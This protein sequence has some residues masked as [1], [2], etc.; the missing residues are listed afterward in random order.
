MAPGVLVEA[1]PKL[2]L[3][4]KKGHQ[5]AQGSSV[6]EDTSAFLRQPQRFAHL[7]QEHVFQGG[8]G[9]PHLV[10]R[11][12]VVEQ[13]GQGTQHGFLRE[14][15]GHLVAHVPRVVQL[16]GA[17]QNGTNGLITGPRTC[18]ERLPIRELFFGCAHRVAGGAAATHAV[19]EVVCQPVDQ[20]V[21]K[22]AKGHWVEGF[23]QGGMQGE[24][25]AT[26]GHGGAFHEGT[27]RPFGNQSASTI[28][29]LGD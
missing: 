29:S 25:G 5:V 15:D 2:A 24:Q 19:V 16:V 26:G 10:D 27:R 20:V 22:G 8:V 13:V 1:H 7:V 21:A 9:G 12:P 28:S 11:L 14:R 3:G 18:H 6:A 23:A 4:G 17:F